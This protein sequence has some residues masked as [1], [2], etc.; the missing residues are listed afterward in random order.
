LSKSNPERGEVTV[1]TKHSEG[2][3]VADR[4]RSLRERLGLTQTQLAQRLG[5][6]FMSVSRWEN[7]HVTPLP[8]FMKALESLENQAVTMMAKSNTKKVTIKA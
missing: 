3:E 5:V 8:A 7:G 1:T 2:T 4:I 6:S